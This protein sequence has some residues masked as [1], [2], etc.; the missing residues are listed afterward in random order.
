MSN[1][2]RNKMS[3]NDAFDSQLQNRGN[4]FFTNSPSIN[5]NLSSQSINYYKGPTNSPSNY[6]K[7]T[8]NIS[9]LNENDFLDEL[10]RQESPVMNPNLNISTN[11]DISDVNNSYINNDSK[12]EKMKSDSAENSITK[13]K[14]E[15][16]K[17]IGQNV[18][19]NENIVPKIEN[20]VSV[21]NLCCKLNLKNI[22][23][24][25]RN[26]EYNPKRFSAAIIRQK[27][28]KTTALIFSNGK[29]VCLGAK[30]E[31]D[32]K[33]AC[34]KFAKI[35]KS[36]NYS[37]KFTDF[38]IVNIVGSVDVQFPINLYNLYYK[39]NFRFRNINNISEENTRRDL[40]YEPEL[41][42]G[43]FYRLENLN[44]LVFLIFRSGKMSI[45]GG[46]STDQIYQAFNH[47]YPVLVDIQRKANKKEQMNYNTQ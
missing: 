3:I 8:E 29:I 18:I 24:Q 15:T 12:N 39:L 31:S 5:L 9:L 4:S 42:P 37:V 22:A 38:K 32:S 16:N 40:S 45:V 13:T 19:L 1:N 33:K 10:N 7:K 21:V 14:T 30:S 6:N 20:I 43:L 17:N 25:I 36:L 11:N 35:I 2:F 46:K 28:P 47:F 23:I 44:Q 26:A 27:E 34:R 41:F